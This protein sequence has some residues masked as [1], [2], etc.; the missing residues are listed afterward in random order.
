MHNVSI[1]KVGENSFRVSG[2]VTSL[3]WNFKTVTVEGET[4]TKKWADEIT[5]N[6]DDEWGKENSDF[7]VYNT[8]FFSRVGMPDIKMWY[9]SNAHTFCRSYQFSSNDYVN[10]LQQL[11][12]YGFLSRKL[13]FGKYDERCYTINDFFNNKKFNVCLF[14]YGFNNFVYTELSYQEIL[15]LNVDRSFIQWTNNK[16]GDEIFPNGY[17]KFNYSQKVEL[18]NNFINLKVS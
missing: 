15:Q 1:I 11:D 4:Y 12:Y 9:Y 13:F 8:D 2:T 3:K 14:G 7:R 17:E 18:L 16:L 6:L 10:Y 5:I